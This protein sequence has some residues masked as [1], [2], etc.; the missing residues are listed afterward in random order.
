MWV[1]QK[2]MDE[3]ALPAG[4][5]PAKIESRCRK[6]VV[7]G[8]FLNS[9]SDSL[10]GMKD[11]NARQYVPTVFQPLSVGTSSVALTHMR[12]IRC[13]VAPSTDL[14]RET[15]QA[16]SVHT[17][18][19]S[20][21]SATVARVRAHIMATRYV[22]LPADNDSRLVVDIDLAILGATPSR[23]EEFERDVR[24]EYRWVPGIVYRP[25]ECVWSRPTLVGGL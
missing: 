7:Q 10:Q 3:Y 1:N 11:Q 4:H 5:R 9:T 13:S 6:S 25:C 24:Q 8:E 15:T 18:C 17:F 22:A 20:P 14:N 19:S 21:A 23:H 12:P 16:R 2:P